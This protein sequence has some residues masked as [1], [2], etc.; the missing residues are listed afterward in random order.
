M[1][2]ALRNGAA[3]E[4]LAGTVAYAAALR[5]AQFSSNN[6]FGDWNTAHHSFTFANAVESGLRRVPS[7]LLL[8]GVFDGAMTVDLIRRWLY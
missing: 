2:E 8:R 1:L 5:I 3:F 4:E 7:P 6:D